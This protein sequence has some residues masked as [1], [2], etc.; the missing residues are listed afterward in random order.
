[1]P[2][3]MVSVSVEQ[4]SYVFAEALAKFGADLIAAVKAGGG[5]LPEVTAIIT[6]AVA[7][8]VPAAVA[9]GQ[10]P[11]ELKDDKFA[12]AKSWELAGT[13]FVKAVLG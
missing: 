10:I 7:D 1:M 8:L 5:A 6:A 11:A 12:F 4:N 2:V 9:V 13:D 3:E